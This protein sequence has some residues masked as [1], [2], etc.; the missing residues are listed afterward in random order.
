[1]IR[2]CTLTWDI[3]YIVLTLKVFPQVSQGMAARAALACV[4][5]CLRR[6]AADRQYWW[7]DRQTTLG[8]IVYKGF[9]YKD[10]TLVVI[11]GTGTANNNNI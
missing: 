10:V 5:A 2:M 9:F 7:T 1:M 3:L 4:L 8:F 11:K 6:S